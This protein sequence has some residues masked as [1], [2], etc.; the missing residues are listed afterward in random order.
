ML[1]RDLHLPELFEIPFRQLLPYL[2]LI[3]I[4]FLGLGLRYQGLGDMSFDHDEMGLVAKSKGIFSLGIPYTVFAGEVR[5]IT[6]YEAVPYPLALAGLS[7]RLL[8]VVH[9]A[10]GLYHG[11]ALHRRDWADGMEIV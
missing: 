11:D 5:W 3:V 7:L 8:R 10:T 1:S 4:M 9:A 6:T 2:S